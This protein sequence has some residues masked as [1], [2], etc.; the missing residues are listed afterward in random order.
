M[1]LLVDNTVSSKPRKYTQ[2]LIEFIKSQR[3]PY[4]IIDDIDDY[5]RVPH[6]SVKGIILSG[7]P[8]RIG[9]I[10][11][12]DNSHLTNKLNIAMSAFSLFPSTPILGICFGMQL[13]NVFYGGT[14]VP[15]GR[16]VC[17]KVFLHNTCP[18]IQVCFNDVVK[19]VA[20]GFRVVER[21]EV[22]GRKVIAHI[23]KKNRIGI[24]YHPESEMDSCSVLRGFL[25]KCGIVHMSST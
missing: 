16:L 4:R 1:L 8:L 11:T 17:K 13:M 24:L 18:R 5:K 10:D 2:K 12:K 20:P 25:E 15:F 9:K 23:E 21:I 3:I 19:K 22:D 14:V 6:E 7:S